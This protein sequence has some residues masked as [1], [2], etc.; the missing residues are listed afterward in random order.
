VYTATRPRAL[1][2]VLRNV[3]EYKRSSVKEDEEEDDD[4]GDDNNYNSNKDK[5]EDEDKDMELG[6]SSKDELEAGFG[7]VRK[8]FLST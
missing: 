3:K 2:Y 8:K 7:V 1:V 6:K 4:K 5:D